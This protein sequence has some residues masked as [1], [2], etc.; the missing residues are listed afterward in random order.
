MLSFLYTLRSTYNVMAIW[1]APDRCIENRYH[2]TFS[3]QN[4]HFLFLDFR[5]VHRKRE[6]VSESSSPAPPTA[7]LEAKQWR[8][9]SQRT[10]ALS[11]AETPQ[12]LFVTVSILG[13]S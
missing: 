6:L 9:S 8:F 2:W 1:L 7:S 3:K 12:S 5:R 10:K 11:E 4:R 13:F